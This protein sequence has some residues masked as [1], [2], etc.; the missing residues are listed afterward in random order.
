LAFITTIL[1]TLIGGVL[2]VGTSVVVKRWELLPEVARKYFSWR[3]T[4]GK[5]F[6][7]KVSKEI[8]DSV[9]RLY[10]AARISGRR[11]TA[12]VGPIRRLMRERS[13]VSDLEQAHDIGKRIDK[14][15]D[16]L[17]SYLIKRIY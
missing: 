8:D 14:R 7:A 4:E 11:E 6:T 10:R 5:S 3:D 9:T 1:A 17:E 13:Q 12:I 15:F 16:E 2:A